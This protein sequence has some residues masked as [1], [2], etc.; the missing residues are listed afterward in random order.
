MVKVKSQFVYLEPP[1]EVLYKRRQGKYF[2]VL[3][4]KPYHKEYLRE[5]RFADCSA[6][7]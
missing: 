6:V 2:K 5:L 4:K 1:A 7:L 3:R